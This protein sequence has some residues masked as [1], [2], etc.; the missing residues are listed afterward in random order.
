LFRKNEEIHATVSS[1]SGGEKA[2]LSL[3]QIVAMTPIL[4]ILD[5][6]TN[7]LDLETRDHV[8]QVL[9]DYPGAILVISH[10]ADFLLAIGV[11]IHYGIKGNAS[12]AGPNEFFCNIDYSDNKRPSWPKD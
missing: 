8:I 6:I 2:R 1:L 3:V 11:T 4:L 7:H 10:D 5:E 9:N 12:K